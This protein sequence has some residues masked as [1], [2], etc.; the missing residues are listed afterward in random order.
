MCSLWLQSGSCQ[1]SISIITSVKW[2]VFAGALVIN[3][4]SASS[5]FQSQK[6]VLG[7]LFDS[8]R[9][10]RGQDTSSGRGGDCRICHTSKVHTKSKGDASVFVFFL[11]PLSCASQGR[12]SLNSYYSESAEFLWVA[13]GTV[14]LPSHQLLDPFES[15]LAAD[16]DCQCRSSKPN[17]NFDAPT[18]TSVC[19]HTGYDVVVLRYGSHQNL[20]M[21]N[22]IIHHDLCTPSFLLNLCQPQT[23]QNS[24]ASVLPFLLDPTHHPVPAYRKLRQAKLILSDS[25]WWKS[26]TK[27]GVETFKPNILNP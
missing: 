22:G 11:N 26:V 27:I 12:Q 21:Q 19:F 6:H 2:N 7:F 15:A 14:L 18:W 24:L 3:S 23:C 1:S 8:P 16:R 17:S 20:T 13:L 5:L 4:I 9:L 25:C 10:E